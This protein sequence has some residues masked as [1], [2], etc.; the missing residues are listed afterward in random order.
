MRRI[1]QPVSG[2]D[3]ITHCALY[4]AIEQRWRFVAFEDLK[5]WY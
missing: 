3:N 2:E 1:R 5:A 4:D